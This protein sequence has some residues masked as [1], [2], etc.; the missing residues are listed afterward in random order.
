[1]RAGDVA[2]AVEALG[3]RLAACSSVLLGGRDGDVMEMWGGR[4]GGFLHEV[5]ADHGTAFRVAGD[6]HH[7]QC[8]V[9]NN[10]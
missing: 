10:G 5:Q 8:P 6:V 2:G 3:T 1:M 4:G 9:E 7:G